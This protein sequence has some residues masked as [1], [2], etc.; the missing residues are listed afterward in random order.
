MSRLFRTCVF[1]AALAHN[2]RTLCLNPGTV[3]PTFCAPRGKPYT[4][5]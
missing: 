3:N 5:K 1:L 4:G 2:F